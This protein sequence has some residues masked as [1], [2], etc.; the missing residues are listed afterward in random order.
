MRVCRFGI[1]F[2]CFAFWTPSAPAQWAPDATV[3]IVVPFAAGGPGDILMR[4]LAEH[5]TSK[6]KQT[7]IIES[8]PGAGSII[9]TEAV[10]RSPP[11]G[12]TLLLVANSFLINANLKSR[13]S[14]D[15]LTSF[16]PI[17]LLA[18]SPLILAVN[19]RSHY[20]SFDQLLS[21]ARGS[22]NGISIGATGP[23]TTQHVA[24]EAIAQAAG[25]QITFVPFRGGPDA[26]GSLRGDHITAVLA[27]YADLKAHLG[28]ELRALAVGSRDR[29]ADLADVPTFSEVGFGEVDGV[30]WIGLVLPAATPEVL[31]T[32]I[33]SHFRSA[34]Q[35]PEVG[36][37]LTA[38]EFKAAGQC[39]A[40]F[41]TYLRQENARIARVI[42]ASN[43]KGD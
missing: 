17:C 35:A 15:P 12:T 10:L 24:I 16:A 20:L 43:M 19:A 21:A 26:T 18:Y 11:D 14:Y 39:G 2:C 33:A 38:L 25:A 6:T 23:N 36:A 8:R 27:N 4:L 42:K 3:R 37:K 22:Q 31:V 1:V 28:T 32:R 40:E 7:I 5:I 30:A 13:L 29:L 9:G 34:L 41:G